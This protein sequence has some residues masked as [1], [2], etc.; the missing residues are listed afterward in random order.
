MVVMVVVVISVVVVSSS[1][2]SDDIVFLGP[3]WPAA[4]GEPKAVV[5]RPGEM[6]V[7]VDSAWP[8]PGT[9][10]VGSV[11]V[12]A[13]FREVDMRGLCVK[14]AVAL[15]GMCRVSSPVPD[16]PKYSLLCRAAWIRPPNGYE[17]GADVGGVSG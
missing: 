16:C 9:A 6:T 3:P 11:V 10:C 15:T 17:S 7:A 5:S 2:G 1:I 8:A 13:G 4:E 12:P 14:F